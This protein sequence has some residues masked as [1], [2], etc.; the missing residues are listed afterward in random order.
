MVLCAALVTCDSLD[1]I[2]DRHG[3]RP[4]PLLATIGFAA[5]LIRA[6]T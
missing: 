1:E 5:Y 2:A 4:R 3:L 6:E